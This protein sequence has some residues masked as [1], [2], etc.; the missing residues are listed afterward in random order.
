[1]SNQN[2]FYQVG[3]FIQ[4]KES[5]EEKKTQK[6]REK[7]KNLNLD[8]SEV[9]DLKLFVSSEVSVHGL[10]SLFFLEKRDHPIN[11]SVKEELQIRKYIDE[12]EKITTE[13]LKFLNSED[14]K[15]RLEKLI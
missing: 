5:L 2:E 12:S 9:K 3:E 14:V 11:E 1:M 8:E 6:E 13:G 4:Y 10:I 7:F 15:K